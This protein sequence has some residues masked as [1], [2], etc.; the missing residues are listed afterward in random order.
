MGP[1]LQRLW[2]MSLPVPSWPGQVCRSLAS[3]AGERGLACSASCWESCWC[4]RS[5][6]HP[7][8]FGRAHPYFFG[9]FGFR[10]SGTKL[11]YLL[12]SWDLS[13]GSWWSHRRRMT[14]KSI[15][16]W[17][18]MIVWLFVTMTN[19]LGDLWL[20][21]VSL[22]SWAIIHEKF[23]VPPCRVKIQGLALIGCVSQW[24]L[25][26]GFVLWA[27]IFPRVKTYDLWLGDDRTCPLFP[28]WRCR[29]WRSWTS[30]AV[31]V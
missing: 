25:V 7:V 27:R 12:P 15:F 3:A 4:H 24:V 28:S 30:R 20:V 9:L 11:S 2:P 10:G 8:V 21:A 14:C 23:K 13:Y 5:S 29:Y 6:H 19:L 22:V 26:E 17:L 16:W 31:M 1:M 18:A